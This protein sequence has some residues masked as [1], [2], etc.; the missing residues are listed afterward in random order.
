M[1]SLGSNAQTHPG[2]QE[3]QSNKSYD[4]PTTSVHVSELE[5]V[6]A[7]GSPRVRG[8]SGFVDWNMDGPQQIW[9]DMTGR[10]GSDPEY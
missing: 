5:S 3:I 7:Q 8:S 10:V 9:T 4:M 1:S 2:L 6:C